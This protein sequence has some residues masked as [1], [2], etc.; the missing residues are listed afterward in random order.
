MFIYD[1][2]IQRSYDDLLL[3]IQKKH[4]YPVKRFTGLY[5]FFCNLLIAISS[6]NDVVLIDSDL[7]DEELR[8]LGVYNELNEK[9]TILTKKEIKTIDALI[10]AVKNSKSKLSVFTSGTTGQPKKIEHTVQALSRAVRETAQ[11]KNV[12]WG[13]AYSPTHMAGL[14]VF[15]QALFNKNAMVNI[16][17]KSRTEVLRLIEEKKITHLSATPTFYRLLL[18]VEKEYP[19]LKRLTFGGEK[20][21]QNL[22]DKIQQIF[23]NAKINNIYASTEAGSLFYAKGDTFC[24]P[25]DIADKIKIE[26]NELLIHRTLLGKSSSL[27]LEKDFYHSGDLVELISDNPLKFRFKSRKNE[28]INV[29]GYKV[30]P[31]EVEEAIEKMEEVKQVKVFGKPNSVLGNILCADIV[32]EAHKDLAKKVLFEKLRTKLQDYKIPRI[33]RY[34]EKIELTRTGKIKR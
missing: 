8:N 3:D 6:N 7:Q 24:V 25:P 26:K 2:D 20:S 15:F 9:K 23:P 4:Y 5:D 14:Q 12:V 29:G 30:N 34:V 27:N 10:S 1:K 28:M 18:P 21:D 16:F 19:L 13:Y 22:Y 31:T 33:I 17:S 11:S 32:V